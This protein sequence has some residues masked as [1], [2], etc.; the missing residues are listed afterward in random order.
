MADFGFSCLGL[1]DVQVHLVS[2]EICSEGRAD[3]LVE[4]EGPVVGNLYKEAHDRLL[5]QRRLS[6]EETVVALHD[7][8]MHN[9]PQFEFLKDF[10]PQVSRE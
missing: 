1:D 2:V 9:V 5:V 8:S 7:V 4:A 6:I 3:T 10:H